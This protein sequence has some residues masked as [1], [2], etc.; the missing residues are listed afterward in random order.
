MRV[1]IVTIPDCPNRDVADARVR[2]ALALSALTDVEPVHRVIGSHE[3]AVTEG[4]QGS[5]TIRFDGTDPFASVGAPTGY[6]CRI[7]QT[8]QG[9][10]GVPTVTQLVG[11]IR[12]HRTR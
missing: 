12:A 4:Y 7:Y 10:A 2:R 8:E 3:Q 1:E 6:S 9:L 5:P 11:A